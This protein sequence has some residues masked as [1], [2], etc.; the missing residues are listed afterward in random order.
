MANSGGNKAFKSGTKK[1]LCNIMKYCDQE[2]ENGEIIVPI[3]QP[4]K[5]AC[6]IAGVSVSTIQRIR[7]EAGDELYPDFTSPKK[8]VKKDVF[9]KIAIDE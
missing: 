2:T 1:I 4:T 8:R 6:Q 3:T 9:D 5:R 7:C